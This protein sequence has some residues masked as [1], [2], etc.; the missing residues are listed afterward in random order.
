[1]LARRGRD[2][3]GREEDGGGCS[4]REEGGGRVGKGWGGDL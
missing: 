2:G 3:C 1:V 4:L